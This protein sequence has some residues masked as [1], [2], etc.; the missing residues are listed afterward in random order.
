MT[1]SQ[2]RRCPICGRASDAHYTPFCS[3]RCANVDLSRWLNET[4]RIPARPDV[5]EEDSASEDE[6]ARGP[7]RGDG[8][9]GT[10]KPS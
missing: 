9:D 5:D 6:G 7:E 2:A 8:A 10:R 4:Y 1:E 3:G